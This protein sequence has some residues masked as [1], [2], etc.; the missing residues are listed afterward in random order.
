MFI[1]CAALVALAAGCSSSSAR[2]INYGTDA[3][4]GYEPPPAAVDGEADTAS[5]AGA[6]GAAGTAGAG[7]AGAAGSTAGAAGNDAA[8][9]GIS[10][11]G[12]D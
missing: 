3:Q 4:S 7:T 8:T 2:D 10:D 12:S 11:G 9:D 5:A 6:D 1:G